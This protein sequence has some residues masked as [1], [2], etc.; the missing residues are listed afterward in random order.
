MKSTSGI[1]T[2][3]NLLKVAAL[4]GISIFSLTFQN[5]GAGFTSSV[6]KSSLLAGASVFASGD[7]LPIPDGSGNCYSPTG[8][9]IACPATPTPTP[10]PVGYTPTPTPVGYTPTPTP[11]PIG[12][13]PT[14]TP[15]GATP[16]PPP[17]VTTTTD[18]PVEFYCSN[19]IRNGIGTSLSEVRNQALTLTFVKN[20]SVVCTM[21]DDSIRTTLINQKKFELNNLATACP[22]VTSGQYTLYYGAA[23]QNSV[24]IQLNP[25]TSAVWWLNGIVV[26]VTASGTARSLSP[27]TSP[28]CAPDWANGNGTGTCSWFYGIYNQAQVLWSANPSADTSTNSN[29]NGACDTTASPLIVSLGDSAQTNLVLTAPLSGIKFDIEGSNAKPTAYAKKQIS[30]LDEKSRQTNYFVVLP[31]SA[32]Q[33]N[34]IDEMFGDNTAGPTATKY[35]ANGYAALAKW[36]GRK[37]N[38]TYDAKSADGV[39]DSKDAV[40]KDLR[41]WNDINGDGIAQENELHTLASMHVTAIDLTYD[42]S[43]KE[44]DKYGN[45]VLFKSVVKTD[46][47]NLHLI[48][49]IWFRVID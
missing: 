29:G 43:Y 12:A 22:N 2:S 44:E 3:S 5:C 27:V 13:T 39:I 46:D 26:N 32:G 33:V 30:W 1:S 40:F 17:V 10:T 45:K 37:S 38:G 7:G 34:G 47:G 41:L 48:F 19:S 28:L 21:T 11:T 35:A 4:A 23:G 31:N 20:G 16:T 42:P 36:D 49:D 9:Q 24:A 8:A 25:G 14:P 15:V 18:L 6:T